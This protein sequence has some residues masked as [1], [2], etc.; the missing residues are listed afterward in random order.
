MALTRAS[1]R[2]Y[3]TSA[4]ARAVRGKTVRADWSPLLAD[5][6]SALLEMLD[7]NLPARPPERQLELL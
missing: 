3:L 7:L 6:P 1:E 2:L 5:L 4:A